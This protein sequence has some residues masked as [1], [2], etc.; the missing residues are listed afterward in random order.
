MST[1]DP[2]VIVSATR[3]PM[4]GFSGCLSAVSAPSLGATAIAGALANA[5]L[6]ND[7][8][9]EVILQPH[10]VGLQIISHL[11]FVAFDSVEQNHLYASR[12]HHAL[13]E[14]CHCIVP[15]SVRVLI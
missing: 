15:A 10:C 4:G 13:R 5:K 3:T 6:A 8:V 14:I 11:F 7:Q 12:L 2:I 9:D 1:V